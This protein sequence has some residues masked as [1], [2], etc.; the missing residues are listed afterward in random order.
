MLVPTAIGLPFMM[1]KSTTESP[2]TTYN[3]LSIQI[4][5]NGF[6]FCVY[7]RLTHTITALE[8]HSFHEELSSPANPDG[9]ADELKRVFEK[10]GALQLPFK[11]VSLIHQNELATF[12]PLSLFDETNLADYLAYNVRVMENDFIAYDFIK[13]YGL[14]NV[15]IPYVN[16]NNF[17]FEWFGEFEYAHSSGLL[18]KSLL[19]RAPASKDAQLFAHL[20]SRQIDL[21]ALIDGALLFYNTFH[22]T[23]AEDALYY[24][25]FTIEQLGLSAETLPVH[26]SGSA[27]AKDT[28]YNLAYTYI[29]NLAIFEGFEGEGEGALYDSS[30]SKGDALLLS[31]F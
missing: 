17:I 7:N 13:E 16:V 10:S 18:V 1:R 26:L 11:K 8:R 21:V 14:V 19:K 23:T 31:S 28:I 25:L 4:G 20:H 12:V 15:Y 30:V 22:Y 3:E 24:L 27:P 2:G 5:L 6:S 29:R 9:I